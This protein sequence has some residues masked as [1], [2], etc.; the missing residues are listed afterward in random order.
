MFGGAEGEEVGCPLCAA[1]GVV[2]SASSDSN[3]GRVETA[4]APAPTARRY[5]PCLDILPP[6][7][8]LLLPGFIVWIHR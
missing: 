4:S 3:R 2:C 6:P 5:D 7:A 1:A 8:A